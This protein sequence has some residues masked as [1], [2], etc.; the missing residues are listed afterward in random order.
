MPWSTADCINAE[1]IA[2][3]IALGGYSAVAKALFDM[4]P[5]QIVDEV[6]E[7]SLRGR[8]GGGF[9]AGRKWQQVLDQDVEEKY[10]VCNGDEGDPRGIYGSFHDGGRTTSCH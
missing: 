5:Q 7:A 1:S 6:S 8:G 3:Y 9:P 10:V 4:T 2:E